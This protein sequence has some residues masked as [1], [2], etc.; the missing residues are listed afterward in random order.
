M[1]QKELLERSLPKWPQMIVTGTPVTKEQA[2]E[3]I[4]RTDIFF[5]MPHGNDREF[6]K[7]ASRLLGIPQR[8]NP[9]FLATETL[10][11]SA[12]DSYWE[13]LQKWRKSWGTIRTEY[14]YN[15]W[16]SSSYVDG[17]NGWCHPDGTIGF[18]R[19]VGKYPSVEDI[20]REWG[21]IAEAFPFLELEVTLMD[22]EWC[23]E[24]T[25]PIVSMLIR[26]GEVELVDPKVR[27]LHEEFAHTIVAPE[28]KETEFLMLPPSKR[29]HAIGIGQILDWSTA[30]HKAHPEWC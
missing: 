1:N 27:N 19:N 29:E 12:F 6:I 25:S 26:N 24:D 18:A 23:E 20:R 17:P 11:D 3:I 10:Y 15:D 13:R 30:F 28:R 14:V 16:V 7:E 9:R 4:R 8:P 22:G 2:L 5:L 21:L